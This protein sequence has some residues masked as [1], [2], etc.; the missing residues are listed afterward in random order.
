[1]PEACGP[2]VIR[3]VILAKV[4]SRGLQKTI[5]PSEVARSLNPTDW[6]ALMPLVREVGCELANSG[7][8]VVTQKGVVVNPETAKG[9]IRYRVTEQGLEGV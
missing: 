6:R 7:A 8:I 5:C 3:K 9:A 2:E 4:R 1:M